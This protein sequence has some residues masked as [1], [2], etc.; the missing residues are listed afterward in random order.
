MRP[1]K[2]PKSFLPVDGRYVEDRGGGVAEEVV[3]HVAEGIVLTVEV[4][5]VHQQHLDEAGLVEVQVQAAA[6]A[7]DDRKASA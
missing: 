1:K 4:V 2:R 6:E 7:A 5:G 3:A